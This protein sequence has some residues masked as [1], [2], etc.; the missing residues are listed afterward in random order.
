MTESTPEPYAPFGVR[1]L[2]HRPP[3][4]PMPG[5]ARTRHV[6]GVHTPVMDAHQ[7]AVG[8]QSLVVGRQPDVAVQGVGPV[9]DGF[10]VRGERM[11]WYVRGGAS[12]GDDLDRPPLRTHLR[13]RARDGHRLM[14]PPAPRAD[15]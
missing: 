7:L 8:G 12:A 1:R 13:G 5:V 4:H 3:M 9:R 14:L 15:L 2:V 6:S 11:F 10:P